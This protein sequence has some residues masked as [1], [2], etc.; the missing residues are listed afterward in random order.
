MAFGLWK[1]HSDS[2]NVSDY[3]QERDEIL[4]FDS[5]VLIWFLHGNENARKKVLTE[6]PFKIS[7]VSYME[8]VQGMKN[9]KELSAF[10]N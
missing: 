2:E 3:V 8:L 6:A 9:K 1:N 7:A 10:K 5:D 4:I